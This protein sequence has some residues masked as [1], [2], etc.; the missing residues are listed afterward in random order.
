MDDYGM[1]QVCEQGEAG[2]TRNLLVKISLCPLISS[3]CNKYL[4]TKHLLF[5][6]CVNCL[7]AFEAPNHHSNILFCLQLKMAFKV[8]VSA[9][10]G[11]YSALL[12]LSHV[13]VCVHAQLLSHVQLFCNSM[14]CCL[15]GSSVHE[16]SLAKVLKA[17]CY[18]LL[19]G[20]FLTQGSTHVSCIG[21]WILYHCTTS[22][23]YMLLNC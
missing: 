1:N 3:Q 21:S 18:F 16:I 19:R 14:D 11:S 7:P 4:F 8:R 5:C 2:I 12:G 10:W 22:H 9:I 6:L 15:P 17:G 20:I 13:W 23:V